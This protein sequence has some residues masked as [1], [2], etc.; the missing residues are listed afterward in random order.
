MVEGSQVD[1]AGHANDPIYM[2]TDFL[3]FDDAFKVALDFAM[4]DGQT[5]VISFP[6][7]DTGGMAIGHDYAAYGYTETPVE[8]VIGPL[9]GMKITA[10]GVASKID[11]LGGATV[12]N[13]RSAIAEWWG[14]DITEDDAQA[15]LDYQAATGVYLDYA[16]SVV[17]SQR[18]TIF[19][20]TTHGHT[21]TDVPIWAYGPGK[22]VGTLD[23]TQVARRTAAALGVQLGAT[24]AVLFHDLAN[25]YPDAFL[26]TTDPENP[27]VVAGSCRLPVSKDTMT[28][29]GTDTTYQLP[30]LTVHA[31][32]TDKVYVSLI[33]IAMIDAFESGG[34]AFGKPQ[35]FLVENRVRELAIENGIDPEFA[36]SLLD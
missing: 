35:R 2:I 23:N 27:V 8:Y 17:I 16:I 30:G 13:I 31:P 19:G 1:W 21:G 4:E 11:D 25:Y 5:L 14:L 3:A 18:Y 7:H 6:D 15:I 32:A 26:D 10:Y 36:L 28:V 12:A 9:Q 33:A 29:E 22:P 34:K 20:W 24:Q